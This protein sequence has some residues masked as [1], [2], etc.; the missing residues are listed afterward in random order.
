MAKRS[1]TVEYGITTNTSSVLAG[2]TYTFPPIWVYIPESGSRTFRNCFME[3]F[4][5]DR[6]AAATS[7]TAWR[8]QATMSGAPAGTLDTLGDGATVTSLVANSGEN[9][10]YIFHRDVTSLFT[11]SFGNQA[12]Q[13]FSSSFTLTGVASNNATA[14][15]F[16]T[17]D[18]EDTTA[19]TRIKTIRLPIES[20][21]G[22]LVFGT[23]SKYDPKN[24]I[25][26]LVDYLPECDKVFRNVFIEFQGNDGC[27][28][29]GATSGSL[30]A[31]LSCSAY[32]A[33][34]SAT[35]T[36]TVFWGTLASA[37]G[38]KYLW[39]VTPFFDTTQVHHLYMGTSGSGGSNTFDCISALLT[40]TYEYNHTNTSSS[41]VSLMLP[42]ADEGAYMGGPATTESSS[43][44]RKFFIE[45]PG[46]IQLLQSGVV[47]TF[48]DGGALTMNVRA[49][50]QSKE[51]VYVIPARVNCGFQSI[52][53]R[54]DAGSYYGATGSAWTLDRGENSCSL[55]WWRTAIPAVAT[56]GMGSST[57]AILYLNYTCSKST[58]SGGDAE[59]NKT[60]ITLISKTSGSGGVATGTPI[61]ECHRFSA[62]PHE[63]HSASIAAETGYYLQGVGYIIHSM[64][65]GT[66]QNATGLTLQCQISGSKT[67]AERINNSGAEWKE[68]CNLLYSTDGEEGVMINVGRGIDAFKRYAEDPDLSRWN[69]KFPRRYRLHS[70]V[71]TTLSS[72]YMFYSYHTIDFAVSG[73][74][75]GYTGT[76][77]GIP[78]NIYRADSHEQILGPIYTAPG[79]QYSSSWYDNTVPLYAEAIQDATHVGRSAEFTASG[80]P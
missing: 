44:T 27:L 17:Y 8:I 47:F 22:S 53:H 16:V 55:Y 52:T 69:I 39:N 67:D 60:L 50:S 35:P 63:Y 2:G 25:P 61:Q 40:V 56:Q 72:T 30:W 42:A 36:G 1:K 6:A 19:V 78:V 70:G 45:E 23:A 41:I 3:V 24:Q 31:V 28:T 49:N 4:V 59:H 10:S 7:A 46:P 77:G 68:L 66:T 38:F 64:M 65:G 71:T 73:T 48:I 18:Y 79:G 76:G 34:M 11:S 75:S 54:L 57:S 80:N 29:G 74:V 33:T 37:R 21:T 51:K 43:F 14:K 12:S 13:S 20:H 15:L 62:W 26:D 5:Q 58:L 32:Q 9:C